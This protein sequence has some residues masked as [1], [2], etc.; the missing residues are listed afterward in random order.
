VDEMHYRTYTA[1]QIRALLKR[2]PEFEIVETYD[3]DYDLDEPMTID[4]S[5]EDVVFVLRKR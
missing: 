5:T 1:R 4:A 3:F 2:V